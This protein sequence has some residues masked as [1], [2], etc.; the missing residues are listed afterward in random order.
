MPSARPPTLLIFGTGWVLLVLLGQGLP[1][2]L[3]LDNP[4]AV[5]VIVQPIDETH[6]GQMGRTV[7][8]AGLSVEPS[9]SRNRYGVGAGLG[10]GSLGFLWAARR[11]HLR[12]N[13]S[14]LFLRYHSRFHSLATSGFLLGISKTN[15]FCL[16]R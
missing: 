13:T 9:G 16:G 7:S 11:S 1:L 12:F 6:L 14:S 5:F 15:E 3:L 4:V 8:I 2:P 10:C